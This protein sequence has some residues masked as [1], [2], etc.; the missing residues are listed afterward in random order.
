M[1]KYRILICFA[2]FIYPFVFA[3]EPDVPEK[4]YIHDGEHILY[5]GMTVEEVKALLGDPTEIRITRRNDPL[6]DFDIVTWVYSEIEL[7]FRDASIKGRAYASNYIE[8]IIIL[9]AES[10][11][12]IGDISPHGK[13][14]EEIIEIFGTPE[15]YNIK[16][17][18]EYTYF[19]YTIPPIKR[20]PRAFILQF[21]F[22]NEGICDE[23]FFASD[24]FF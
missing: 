22:N 9:D 13:T 11:F 8:M 3:T 15:E 17:Y 1:R 16:N 19:N 12:K 10:L 6:H 7:I 4:Y 24:T 2:V 14:V 18:D 5:I 21:R 20:S 23:M